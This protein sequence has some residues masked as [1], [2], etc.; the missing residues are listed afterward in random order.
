MLVDT[1]LGVP[2]IYEMFRCRIPMNVASVGIPRLQKRAKAGIPCQQSAT[3]RKLA[4]RIA[5]AHADSIRNSL[6][7]CDTVRGRRSKAEMPLSDEERPPLKRAP[8]YV[9]RKQFPALAIG[10]SAGGVATFTHRLR[11]LC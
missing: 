11:H 9:H 8:Q 2:A 7:A 5:I 4:R 1:P 3:G 10:A 6:R